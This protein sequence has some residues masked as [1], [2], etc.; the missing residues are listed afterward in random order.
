MMPVF[1]YCGF[2]VFRSIYPPVE[3]SMQPAAPP[4]PR[5]SRLRIAIIGGAVALFGLAILAVVYLLRD[6]DAERALQEAIAE[7]DRLDPGW[8]LE[9]MEAARKPVAAEKNAALLLTRLGTAHM[10]ILNTGTVRQDLANIDTEIH[11]SGDPRVPLTPKQTADLRSALQP[12]APIRTESRKIADMPSGRYAT[13]VKAELSWIIPNVDRANSTSWLLENDV[14]LRIADAEMEDAWVSC[15]TVLNAGRS[16]GDEPLQVVQIVR[17]RIA[18]RAVGLMERTLAHGVVPEPRLAA[19]QEL[20]RDELTHPAV[21][22]S[23]RSNRAMV[24]HLCS[25]LQSGRANLSEAK[26]MFAG[27]S[28]PG[29]VVD[30]VQGFL[31]RPEIKPAHTWLLHYTTQAVEIGKRPEHEV[32][33]AL[34]ELEKTLADAPPLARIF[35]PRVRHLELVLTNRALARCAMAAL[36]VERFRLEHGRWPA[37]LEEVVAV[38][39]LPEVPLDPF[40]GRPLR[41][42]AAADGVVVYSIGRNGHGNGEVL[43]AAVPDPDAKRVEFRLWNVERRGQGRGE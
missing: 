1:A 8:R 18:G 12:L 2:G 19:T 34:T 24:H 32:P 31:G 40:D 35:A 7:A 28:G 42:R 41:W 16:L 27:S 21:L 3:M 29:D 17:G 10:T 23:L 33:S 6:R 26:R 20:L 36:A 22:I 4:Q 15:Q 43:D 30:Q 25:L 13:N 39:L 38:K 14:A 9:E 37:A 5:R 11:E